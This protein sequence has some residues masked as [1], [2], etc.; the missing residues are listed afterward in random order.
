MASEERGA[1]PEDGVRRQRASTMTLERSADPLPGPPSPRTIVTSRDHGAP[2][3]DGSTSQ[4]PN[5]LSSFVTC[6][7]CGGPVLLRANGRPRVHPFCDKPEC[8]RRASAA[9]ARASRAGKRLPP[10]DPPMPREVRTVYGNNSDLIRAVARLYLPDGAVVLDVT[11]GFGVFWKRFKG[12][13]RFTLIGSDIRPLGGISVQAD[14]RKLPYADA[15]VDV[16]VLDPPYTPCG[17][18][19][20]NHRYGSALTDHLR[21]QQILDL[22][23][24]GMIEAMRVLRPGGTLWVKCKDENDHTQNRTHCDLRDIALELRLQREDLKD[25]FL[26][27]PRPAPTRRWRRQLHARKTYLWVFRKPVRP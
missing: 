26:L 27:A 1:F 23:R 20:N 10:I 9:R 4:N 6:E 2:C 7:N 24:A 8:R 17:H 19:L 25:L 12:R 11:W 3:Q 13:R 21:H 15:G 5:E 16:V 14:F 22:Y 18:Y